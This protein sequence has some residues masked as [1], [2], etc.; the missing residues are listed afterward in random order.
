[1]RENII[2]PRFSGQVL[3]SKSRYEHL[4]NY[5]K[6]CTV[7]PNAPTIYDLNFTNKMEAYLKQAESNKY[8]LIDLEKNLK[9]EHRN[10][11]RDNLTAAGL[12]AQQH[13]RMYMIEALEYSKKEI[14]ERLKVD[15]R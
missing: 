1:M 13:A 15:V 6:N 11:Y 10:K 8:N 9:R 14:L 5:I 3:D 2:R 12:L 4:I 7:D